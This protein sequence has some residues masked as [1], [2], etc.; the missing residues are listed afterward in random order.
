MQG[1]LEENWRDQSLCRA[2]PQEL[3]FPERENA[4]TIPKAKAVCH[5]CPVQEQCLDYALADPGLV[6]IWGG[7]TDRERRRLRVM[8]AGRKLKDIVNY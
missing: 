4:E 7:T 3:F 8:L 1:S 2:Y 6:G 5:A